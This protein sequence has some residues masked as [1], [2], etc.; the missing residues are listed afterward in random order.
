M[1]NLQKGLF[2]RAT[3]D[4]ISYTGSNLLRPG[5]LL[6]VKSIYRPTMQ[7]TVKTIRFPELYL[8]VTAN[9]RGEVGR[10][11]VEK[12]NQAKAKLEWV[13]LKL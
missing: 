10:A 9:K 12:I 1:A 6:Y 11:D 5:E 2:Y 7:A 13:A 3:E 4:I 8:Y